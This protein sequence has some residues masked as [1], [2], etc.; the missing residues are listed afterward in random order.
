[1]FVAVCV[2]L[3][4][5]AVCV[6]VSVCVCAVCVCLCV[7][8]LCRLK[9]EFWTSPL[10]PALYFLSVFQLLLLLPNMKLLFSDFSQRLTEE[11]QPPTAQSAGTLKLIRA[12]FQLEEKDDNHRRR[13][14]THL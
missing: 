8:T 12:G 7:C 2:C 4:L 1:M 6:C 13:Q 11:Q 9:K 10:V 5:C 14:I 3:C